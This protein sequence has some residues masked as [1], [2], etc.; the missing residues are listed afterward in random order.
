MCVYIFILKYNK[1][2]IYINLTYRLDRRGGDLMR[3]TPHG[4]TI[5]VQ[6]SLINLIL[7]LT[8][9]LQC[10]VSN[11]NPK[12]IAYNEL[13]MFGGGLPLERVRFFIYF[14]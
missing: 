4:R 11:P 3:P 6:Y 12:S 8:V 9:G 14:L 2:Y 10:K 1:L 7:T 5:F 13:G